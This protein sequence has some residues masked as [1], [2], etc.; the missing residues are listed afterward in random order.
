VL[1][2]GLSRHVD[3][4]NVDVEHAIHFFQRRLLERFR[5]GRS[6]VVHQ[7]IQSAEGFKRLFDRR[8]ARVRE[9]K[10]G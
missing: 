4:T 6:G 1:Q 8:V 9:L 3:T 7:H 5:N 2:C 10:M